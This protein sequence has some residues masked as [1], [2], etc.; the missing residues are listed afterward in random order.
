[1]P[2]GWFALSSLSIRSVSQRSRRHAHC[3]LL[4]RLR[5]PNRLPFKLGVARMAVL[6]RMTITFL[7]CRG[8]KLVTANPTI[9]ATKVVS[10]YT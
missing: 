3:A 10:G 9:Y 8:A 6:I 7:A 2:L 5:S 1:M 4:A